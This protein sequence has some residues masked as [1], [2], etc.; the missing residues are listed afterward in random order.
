MYNNGIDNLIFKKNTKK[1]IKPKKS[2]KIKNKTIKRNF[3]YFLSKKTCISAMR[4]NIYDQ[5]QIVIT[6]YYNYQTFIL[7]SDLVLKKWNTKFIFENY[8]DHE[9]NFHK[10]DEPYD[11]H[12]HLKINNKD[13]NKYLKYLFDKFSINVKDQTDIK[14]LLFKN[15]QIKKLKQVEMIGSNSETDK[16]KFFKVKENNW[17]YKKNFK[18]DISILIMS[19]YN[20]SNYI[21]RIIDLNYNCPKNILLDCKNLVN[22]L[23]KLD[24]TKSV[25]KIYNESK[26]INSIKKKLFIFFLEKTNNVYNLKLKKNKSSKNTEWFHSIIKQN[27]ENETEYINK[28]LYINSSI[29]FVINNIINNS[30]NY[31]TEDYF[32]LNFKDYLNYRL[33][34]ELAW[35][36]FQSYK[37]SKLKNNKQHKFFTNE[38][39]NKFESLN[40]NLKEIFKICDDKLCLKS[41]NFIIKNCV[42]SDRYSP[43]N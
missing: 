21:I 13:I 20:M 22:Y 14:N 2:S 3:T 19:Y 15:E 5:Y 12:I 37:Y 18:Y 8:E 25:N 16:K 43:L 6:I 4:F 30:L 38:I 36:I 10:K 11:W 42:Q 17:L 9:K 26:K 39:N 27:F 24:V 1:K 34:L 32:K 29:M 28:I 7:L 33:N 35:F 23:N 41:N 31:D 40:I